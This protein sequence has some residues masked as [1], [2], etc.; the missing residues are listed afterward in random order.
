MSLDYMSERG[1]GYGS[2]FT[3]SRDRFFGIPGFTAGLL[4]FWAISDHG[5]D[6]LGR[7]RRAI[8]PEKDYRYRLLWQHRQY[9]PRDY[10][11]T[12]EVG[13]ISDY[14]FLEQYFESEWEEQKDQST[15]VELKK[16]IDNM[17]WALAIDYRMNYFV[18]DTDWLPRFDHYWLG[19]PLL[20]D[21]FTWYEHT[22]VGYARLRTAA[23]PDD[24]G[25]AN[26]FSYL[27]WETSAVTGDP[28][29]T[30]GERV[31]TRQELDWPFL[32]G[33]VKIV[34][35]ALGE[36]GHWGEDRYGEDFQRAYGQLGI[37][38]T[39]PVWAVN[40]YVT[41]ELWNL[42]GLAHKVNFESEFLWADSSA[43]MTDLPLYDPLDDNS[44]E[45][46]RR[47]F[48]VLSY[49]P[50][51]GFA[52]PPIPY[53]FDERSYAL[54][55]GMASWVT[56]PG[57]EIADD[58][59]LLRL[60]ARQRWQTKR[61]LPGQERIVDWIT[62][63]THVNFYPESSRDNFGRFVGLLDYDFRWH[64]GDRLTVTSYGLF[65][66]FDSGQRLWTIG[67][68]LSRPPRGNLYLGLR[69]L[70]GPIHSTILSGAY[71]YRMSDKWLSTFGMSIDLGEADNIG[72]NFSITRIGESFLATA[73]VTVDASRDSVGFNFAVEPRFLPRRRLGEFD[74]AV[75]PVAGSEGLE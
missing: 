14:N 40:P 66:F 22:S 15:G 69:F 20:R 56:A 32:L 4:D 62:L 59:M 10:Q 6:D 51:T 34:P 50:G 26:A 13:L 37:R 70:D 38:A 61:G 72:Q 11:L 9:L 3:Y 31:V 44:I 57:L 23:T 47:R 55:S 36:L 42:N 35:Y 45:A 29:S 54:R 49:G 48:S 33:P 8:A 7:D 75:V 65:D 73:G 24:P 1:F 60:G 43:D 53:R 58:L 2:T 18:T 30:A 41:S 19:Q 68:F 28:L 25:T 63:D 16:T 64:P 39:L 17:T 27:P 5:D 46:F 67:G 52:G 74:G 12:A 71:S 21:T